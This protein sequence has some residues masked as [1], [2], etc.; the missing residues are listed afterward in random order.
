MKLVRSGC[1]ISLENI[2]ERIRINGWLQHK[3]LG[4]QFLIVRDAYGTAQVVVQDPLMMLSLKDLPL[5]SVLEI[6]GVVKKRPDNQDNDDMDS[7]AVEI[8]A[9]EIKI[10]NRCNA[11]L[12]FHIQNFHEVNESLRLK[13]RYLDLRHTKLQQNLRLKSEVLFKME[14]HLKKNRF[15]DVDTP[16]LFRE[17]PGGAREFIVPTHEKGKVYALTQSPQQFKQLLMVGGID[18]YMQVAHCFRDETARP[19]RQPEFTQVDLEMSFEDQEGIKSIVEGMIHHSWPSHL[20]PI[21]ANFP[22]MDYKDAIRI[23]GS[24]KPDIRFD[25]FLQEVTDVFEHCDFVPFKKIHSNKPK[26]SIQA[27]KFPHSSPY[28][29]NNDVKHITKAI[30]ESFCDKTRVFFTIVRV[31]EDNSWI[32]KIGSLLGETTFKLVQEKLELSPGDVFILTAGNNTNSCLAAGKFRTAMASLLREKGI[33]VYK[34]DDAMEF[35]WIENFPLFLPKED[36]SEGLESAHHPFTAPHPDDVE[37]VYSKPESVRGQHYDLVLNGSEVAGGSIRIH[38]AELQ[39]YVLKEVLKE[40]PAPLQHLIDALDYGAPPHGGIALGVER[41]IAILCNAHSIRDVIAFPKSSE[42][43][44]LMSKAP[45]NVSQK[46]LDYY[47]IDFKN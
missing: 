28:I 43:K 14:E 19:D 45:T 6:V 33:S 36:G 5:E 44:C 22:R 39:R 23:Y 20:K 31:K 12:P 41:Y 10:L 18:R 17:T 26:E 4:G 1:D 27:V 9:E 47:H 32:G 46:V 11:H 37:L 25:E 34:E 8:L 7:G 15:I 21:P 40:D 16:L 30:D 35:L 13:Y 42:G 3:R 29:T 38:D 2:S 24:D